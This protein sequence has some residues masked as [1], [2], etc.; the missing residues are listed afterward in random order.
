M[1]LSLYTSYL[2][3]KKMHQIPKDIKISEFFYV[4]NEPKTIILQF[5]DTGSFPSILK[6]RLS[7]KVP[8]KLHPRKNPFDFWC[9]ENL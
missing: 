6:I 5:V 7:K 2:I 8:V 3:C 4:G 1:F 9:P